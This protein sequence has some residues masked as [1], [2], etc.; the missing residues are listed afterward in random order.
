MREM[1]EAERE[2]AYSHPTYC[3]AFCKT[4]GLTPGP[5]GGASINLFCMT[6]GAG[7][8]LIAPEYWKRYGDEV[9]AI[10][11]VLD[12]PDPKLHKVTH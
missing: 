9:K 3:C 6:C 2:L 12:G 11:Q 8:N 4:I 7:F 1:T 10:G 5:R